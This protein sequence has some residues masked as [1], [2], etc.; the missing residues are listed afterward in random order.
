MRLSDEIKIFIHKFAEGESTWIL[1]ILLKV[2]VLVLVFLLMYTVFYLIFKL[3]N[4][5]FK[6]KKESHTL[7]AIEKVKL[8][9]SIAQFIALFA[10]SQALDSLFYSGH[11]TVTQET[12]AA[13]IDVTKVIVIGGIALKLFQAVEVYFT[14]KKQ[15]YQ[16]VGLRAIKQILQIIGGVILF[17]IIISIFFEISSAALWGSLGAITAIIALVFR[18][19]ILGVVTGLHVALSRSL[20]IGDRVDIP[21]YNISGKVL[22]ITLLTTKIL[23]YDKTISTIPTYDLLTTEIKNRQTM[24]DSNRRRIM[25]AL[26]FDIESF[27]F[28][29]EAEIEHLAK[30]KPIA[31]FFTL[32][33]SP[34]T[35]LTNFGAFRA[36]AYQYVKN[37]P[38]IDAEE[39]LV[40][41]QLEPTPYGGMPLEIYCFAKD[42]SFGAFEKIQADIFD[43][44]ISASRVFKLKIL[45]ISNYQP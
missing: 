3:V 45:K 42:A 19:A 30:T 18:D 15:E 25:R 24:F 8:W 27:V 11:H 33:P 23:N 5:L 1:Q 40:I 39:Q 31:D 12:L 28:L 38:N 17:F 13:I 16:L 34:D 32:E 41:R 22:D 29:T 14:L 44:L 21:K 10:C 4:K 37:N 9:K 43:H 35:S 7:Q 6:S 26:I 20:K 2:V 36:Y